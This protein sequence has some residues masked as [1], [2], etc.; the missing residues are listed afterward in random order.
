MSSNNGLY[1]KVGSTKPVPKEEINT[2]KVKDSILIPADCQEYVRRMAYWDR[3]TKSDVLELL[4]RK[5]MAVK[6]YDPIPPK[7][8]IL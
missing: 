4:I 8:D 2:K 6:S 3:T 7:A 5:Q 1:G